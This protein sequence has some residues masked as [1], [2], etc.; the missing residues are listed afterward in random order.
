M[1]F[2]AKI[3]LIALAFS[4][5]GCMQ[6]PDFMSKSKGEP[7]AEE[8]TRANSNFTQP[9]DAPKSEI[10]ETLLNRNSLLPA[11]TPYAEVADAALAASARS[12]EAQLRAAKL[13]AEAK[14]KNWLPTLGPSIS[15]ST[16]GDLV[17]GILVEQVLFD[18]GRR[19]AE[20]E[21]AA[22]DVQVAAVTLSEDLNTRVESA[23]GLYIAALRGDEKAALNER[24]L[25]RMYE[26]ERIVRGRVE[27]GVS[28][29]AD[30]RVVEGKIND[31]ESARTTAHEAA[32]AA[33][34]ELKAMT[35]QEFGTGFAPL[36]MGTPPSS[37]RHLSV[38]KAEA[39]ADRSVAQAKIDRAG[40]LP[41]LSAQANV[42]NSG[43]S[44]GLTVDADQPFGFGTPAM[45]K[46]I[47][48]ARETADRQVAEADEAARRSFSRQSQRLSS[49]RRQETEA[50]Q[51]A[52]ESRE[53]FRLFQAQFKAGQRTVM[54]V[55]AIYEQL[56]QREQAHVDAKY[57]VILI[58]LEMAR[59]L[60]LLA[61]GDK[62]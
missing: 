38:I 37:A 41:G 11:G 31:I 8:V 17:A 42:T 15:L 59:D 56:V 60:G 52:R 45:L 55:A 53:T 62:I 13:R 44:G 23:V 50:A 32:T 22:A 48:A 47:E 43:T 40:L 30:L 34:A 57:E 35:G 51:L 12:S 49:Y 16:L 27:G 54:D 26:F 29:R 7:E 33:R 46:A 36:N 18:N 9:E 39:E 21:F 61:D 25:S 28:D 58:Q 14:N 10:M 3:T 6:A 5:T 2:G 24:A 20:R 1:Q 4:L 19:K